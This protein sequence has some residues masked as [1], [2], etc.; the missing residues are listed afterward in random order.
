MRIL[1]AIDLKNGRCV[2]LLRGE[3]DKETVFAADPV[4]VARKWRDQ[5]AEYLH[6]V[7]LDGA[8]EGTP[9]HFDAVA[10]VVRETG[11]PVQIGGGIRTRDSIEKYLN[12]GLD[13][14]I[15]GTRALEAPDWLAGLCDDFP[16]HIAAGVDARDGRVALRGWVDVSHV[17]A[18]E[19]AERIK[20]MNLSAVIY[21]DISKDG[22]LQG[23]SV[24]A[25]RAFADAVRLPVIA[26]GGVGNLDHVRNLA[27]LPL[28]GIIIGRALYTGAVSLPEAVTIARATP[29]PQSPA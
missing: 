15:I 19:L 6:M 17:T 3:A 2:R 4:E 18:L 14:V 25:T 9:R 28:A 13:R 27:A 5:G 1:P 20:N 22:T 8:F 24:D 12:A 11:L 7:D 21:T 23:P 16:G 29:P 26:S 10:R